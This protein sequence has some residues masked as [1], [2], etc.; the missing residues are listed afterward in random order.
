MVRRRWKP[1]GMNSGR[2]AIFE[3]AGQEVICLG[4]NELG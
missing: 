3:S 4:S 1:D 2:I